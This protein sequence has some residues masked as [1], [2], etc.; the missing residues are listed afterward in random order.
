MN[1]I[2]MQDILFKSQIYAFYLVVQKKKKVFKK[3]TMF[4]DTKP[5]FTNPKYYSYFF[6]HP[7]CP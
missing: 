7:N 4:Q 1:F 3:N 2:S 5:I 6:V